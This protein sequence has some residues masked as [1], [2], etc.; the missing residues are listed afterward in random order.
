MSSRLRA[1]I[2]RINAPEKLPDRLLLSGLIGADATKPLTEQPTIAYLF[3]IS[4]PWLPS[5][6]VLPAMVHVLEEQYTH[7]SAKDNLDDQFE[8]VL[9]AVN[10]KLN[11]VSESG[12]TDWIG[13][14]NGLIL[15]LGKEEIHFSQTG[16]CPAYLLQNNRI[17]QITD[18]QGE[19]DP[20]PLKTFSNLASGHL[21]AGDHILIANM[22]L[23]NEISLDALRRILNSNTSFG[24]CSTIAKELKKERNSKVCSIITSIKPAE[25][26]YKEEAALVDMEEVLQSTAKKAYRKL[27]PYLQAAK[28]SSAKLGKVGAHAAH[29]LGEASLKAAHQAGQATKEKVIPGAAALIAKSTQKLKEGHQVSRPVV[30]V[31]LPLEERL[32]ALEQDQAV[33]SVIPASTFADEQ[34]APQEEPIQPKTFQESALHFVTKTVPTFLITS[35]KTFSIWIE[36]PRNKKITALVVAVIL[37]GSVIWG[38]LAGHN[39]A[40]PGQTT[41]SVA[42]A[43]NQVKEN[44]EKIASAINLEQS[45]EAGRL[46]DDSFKK[47]AALSDLNPQQ[48]QESETLWDSLTT[49]ADTLTNTTRFS[50]GVTSYAFPNNPQMFFASLPY[51]FGYQNNGNAILRTGSGT[52]DEIQGSFPLPDTSEAIAS[53]SPSSESDTTGYILTKQSKV[54]RIAQIGASTKLLAIAPQTGE[55]ANGT[56]I[57]SYSGNIYI[58][59]GGSGLLW[60]YINSGTSYS[61]GTMI[62]DVNKINLKGAISMS[63][64]GSIYLL[65]QDSS[66]TKLTS[67][68]VD[69]SFSIQNVPY[70]SQ[71]LVRPLQVMAKEGVASVYVLDGGSTATEF[72]N[73]K[74]LEFDKNGGFIRQYAFPKNFTDVRAFDINPKDKKLWVLNGTSVTEFSL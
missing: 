61:K 74:I 45:V 26:P 9:R 67:S 55:F 5:S 1:E 38:A 39:Q 3:E 44:Q 34:P 35:L 28:T 16:H 48:K 49:Q 68:K 7:L 41:S 57:S 29:Q 46:L 27:V 24:S 42:T 43:L 72:S 30:E 58:L 32:A 25:E 66:I 18:D 40:A 64:D 20:H 23:Y 52:L 33:G 54:Y 62:I 12:E 50:A 4:R 8:E 65:K 60:R 2:C 47:L 11:E 14:L 59:D 31:I 69:P 70:L 19:K 10:Q 63:I 36:L 56:V 37:V 73:A 15:L 22:E 21:Q 53:I 51:F 71:K 13:N 6:Q 17:R